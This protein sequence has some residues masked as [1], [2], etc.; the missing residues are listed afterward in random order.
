VSEPQ[1]YATHRRFEPLQHFV[2]TP[3]FL[4]TVISSLVQCYR[5]PNLHSA[6]FV[7]LAVG[8]LLLALQVRQY[9]LKVQDR[10]IR[11]EE[12]LRMEHILPDDLKGRISELTP[13]QMVG[14]RFAADAELAHRVREALDEHLS[15]E[16]IKKRIQV[17]RPDTFR[18]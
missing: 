5:H 13:K 2:L 11:L 16:A 6:W 17:W 10:L 3:I 7:V 1:T 14:L 9:A 18:V 4:I 15:G 8:L 12:T